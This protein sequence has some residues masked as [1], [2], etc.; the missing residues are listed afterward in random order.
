[1]VEGQRW[2]KAILDNITDLVWLKDQGGRIIT[3]NEA[4]G[5]T[6]GLNPSDLAGKANHEIFPPDLAD[7]FQA[8]D[9]KVM[10]SRTQK[11]I[12]E[13]IKKDE[14]EIRWF[15]TIKTPVFDAG[16]AVVG[17]V[18]I[19]RDITEDKKAGE[20][21]KEQYKFL[22]VLLD[23]IP[24]PVFFKDVEGIYLGCNRAF[25]ELVGLSAEKILGKTVYDVFPKDIA[26]IYRNA[27]I[28]LFEHPGIQS[29]EAVIPDRTGA[30]RDVIF[31]KATYND[32]EGRLAGLIGTV[33]DITDRK[34]L[35][36]QLLKAQKMEAIGTLAGG[37]AHDFNNLL[38]GI[39]G[40][41]SLMLLD[42]DP[43]HPHYERL[44]A[45]EDQ[46]KSGA[47]LTKQLLGFARGGKY[48]IK[49]TNV[50]ELIETSSLIFGRTKKEI[51]IH[52]KLD[53]GLA[54]A[55]VDRG[56]IQQVLLNLYVNAWHAMPKGG[57]LYLESQN[58]LLGDD[59][60]ALY[61]IKPGS[62]IR[63]LVA[64]TGIG[65]DERTKERIFEPFF[66]TKEMGRGS[67]LGLA[68]AY[69]IIRNHGGTI[70]V[71]SEQGHG[72]TFTIYLPASEKGPVEEK[73]ESQALLKG[74]ETILIVDDQDVVLS[75]GKELLQALGYTVL[76]ANSG[77]EAIKV[78]QMLKDKINLVILDMIMPGM[79]GSETYAGLARIKPDLK[80]L[81]SS[82]YSMNNEAQE[83]LDRGC[84]G[85]I[86]KPFDIMELSYKVRQI[87]EG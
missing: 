32:K 12:E 37:I 38:M 22:Q 4:F 41:A 87:L 35:E 27:D 73:K 58:V 46:V 13:S 75:A 63:I 1:M 10:E 67:G 53:P 23:S 85:F 52:R 57:D 56:Q 62:Y 40:Y 30:K 68:S 71:Y 34:K 70:N 49:P 29:Y 69:G 66:T 2:Q 31:T 47:D 14:K 3:V 51:V 44:K 78:Y 42:V 5:R 55:E 59:R 76:T 77:F 24:I 80:V 64:D 72:T 7:K 26:D 43:D 48:E 65:M 82:G 20:A 60:A 36:A 83:I 6:F 9:E 45:I 11:R 50:N 74:S 19:A 54:P 84:N 17:T 18:G 86:Q 16:G 8:D 28:E 61:S 79:G 81:L 33:H 21:L 15:D 25:E 39:Q